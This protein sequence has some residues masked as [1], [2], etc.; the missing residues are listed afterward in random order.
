MPGLARVGP[1]QNSMAGKDCAVFPLYFF[2][3]VLVPFSLSVVGRWSIVRS[4][5]Q[6]KLRRH[7]RSRSSLRQTRMV[8]CEGQ[9]TVF[10]VHLTLFLDS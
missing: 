3:P 5:R 4:L 1:S 2:D 7:N 8:V 10:V 6:I 9:R